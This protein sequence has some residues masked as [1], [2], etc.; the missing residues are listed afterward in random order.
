MWIA[1]QVRT[2]NQWV[3]RVGPV[4]PNSV[5]I[6]SSYLYNAQST[7]VVLKEIPNVL[8]SVST[9]TTKRLPMPSRSR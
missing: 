3:L 4:T 2:E 6:E 8:T 5:M 9:A 7:A 1:T